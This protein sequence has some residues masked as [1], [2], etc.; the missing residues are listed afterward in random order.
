MSWNR[1]RWFKIFKKQINQTVRKHKCCCRATSSRISSKKR[2]KREFIR[3]TRKDRLCLCQR[4]SMSQ[5]KI[6]VMIS[7][8][9]MHLVGSFFMIILWKRKREDFIEIVWSLNAI[10]GNLFVRCDRIL[11]W[12][13]ESNEVLR[14]E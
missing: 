5:G 7:A 10:F 4:S 14:K 9:I 1:W 6:T 12:N 13:N 2:R 3:I 8:R 11:M